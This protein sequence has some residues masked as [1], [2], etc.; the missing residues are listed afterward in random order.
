MALSSPVVPEQTRGTHRSAWAPAACQCGWRILGSTC[1]LQAAVAR[2]GSHVSLNFKTTH[3]FLLFL[4]S[5]GKH[6]CHTLSGSSLI[7]CQTWKM[8]THSTDVLPLTWSVRGWWK[9]I[10]EIS[11]FL[12]E[13][14]FHSLNLNKRYC[15]FMLAEFICLFHWW[16]VFCW[17]AQLFMLSD[18]IY[19]FI[20]TFTVLL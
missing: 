18:N 19:F 12:F 11:L 16:I 17:I 9:I 5:C 3:C 8:K 15:C 7:H 2:H 4:P 10:L 14:M 13:Q 6:D 20:T 1:Y